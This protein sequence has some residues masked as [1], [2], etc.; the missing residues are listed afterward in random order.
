MSPSPS[1]TVSDPRLLPDFRP[2][3][4]FLS[5]G[6][7]EG[8]STARCEFPYFYV[9][10][11]T[12]QF[13]F[14]TPGFAEGRAREAGLLYL[15]SFID[16]F[17]TLWFIYLLPIFFVVTKLTRGVPPSAIWSS[18]AAWRCAYRD[19]PD[20]DRRIRRA[21]RLFLFRLSVRAALSSR[22]PIARESFAALALQP[23]RPGRCSMARL[24]AA[25]ASE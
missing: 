19:R 23:C 15:E 1:Q 7:G 18:R 24:V 16:P 11:V 3:P 9:L 10:W 17:G 22:C 4:P 5:I 20:P 6:T 21:L 25:R 8:F 13:G 14:E 2:V 12:I